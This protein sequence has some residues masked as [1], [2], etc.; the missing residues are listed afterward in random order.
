MET[1][2]PD[3]NQPPNFGR[4]LKVIEVS[5]ADDNW[6]RVSISRDE[7]GIFRVHSERWEISDLT[8]IGRAYWNT[9]GHSDSLT[10]DIAIAREMA[11][12]SLRKIPRS[13][14]IP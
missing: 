12:D 6:A 9:L 13:T 2:A 5:Y 10:D 14:M 4:N 8:T 1:P 7:R 3:L 11:A